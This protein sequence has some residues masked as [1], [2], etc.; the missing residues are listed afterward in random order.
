MHLRKF[1]QSY[2]FGG[3]GDKHKLIR[4]EIRRSKVKHMSRQ[5]VVKIGGSIYIN[6]ST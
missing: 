5:Y 4:F 1:Y 6:G 3:I 2:S